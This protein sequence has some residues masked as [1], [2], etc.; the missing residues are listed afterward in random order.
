[1]FSVASMPAFDENPWGRYKPAAP[2]TLSSSPI[3]A[4]SP[5]SPINGNSAPQR[6]CFSS[7]PAPPSKFASRPAKP[8]PM[9]RKRDEGQATRRLLFLKNV[10]ERATDKA[11]ERRAIEGNAVRRW[12]EEQQEFA[13]QKGLDT[14]AILTEADIEDAAAVA[15]ASQPD[16]DS[17]MVDDVARQEELELEALLATMNQETQ[18]TP[19]VEANSTQRPPS[20]YYFSDDDEYE[21]IFMQLIQNES[22]SG[23]SMDTS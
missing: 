5:L 19:T 22:H 2:S 21:E 6:S 12:H 1:M 23:D 15:D 9:L 7:P 20:E 10:R 3:R 4:P 16:Y 8:N 18:S 14:A 17:M 11:W 13:R